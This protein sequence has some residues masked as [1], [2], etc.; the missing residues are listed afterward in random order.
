MLDIGCD[1]GSLL[2]AAAESYGVVPFGVDVASRAVSL[3]RSRG[4]DIF[5]GAVEQAPRDLAGFKVVV[6]VDVIEHTADPA[7]FLRCLRERMLPGGVLYIQTPHCHSAVYAIGVLIARIASGRPA[8]MLDR[9]F[10]PEH[11]QYFS[12]AG[13]RDA[14]ARC[15]FEVVSLEANVLPA[16]DIVASAAVRAGLALFQALD[17]FRGTQILLRAVL[18]K[19]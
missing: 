12:R 18:R 16:Q 8:K 17:T 11:V 1:A 15:G 13:L 14:A 2:L 7:M 9:L 4:L 5:H 19:P 3:A 6:A 10:P